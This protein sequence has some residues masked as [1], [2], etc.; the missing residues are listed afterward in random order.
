M[1]I[2]KDK[3]MVHIGNGHAPEHA[4]LWGEKNNLVLAGDQIISSISPNL[5]VY[6]TEPDAD[7]VG[8]WI[9]SCERFLLFA[10]SQQL[11][12]SGHKLPFTGLSARLNQLVRNHRSCLDRLLSFLS[13]PR[14]ACDC[15]EP[16]FKKK[17]GK[18]E[19]LLALAESVAHLNHLQKLGAVVRDVDCQGVYR[20]TRAEN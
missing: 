7:P 11:V 2:G 5:G 6:A 1:E 14:S 13:V 12:L 4:T 15:F 9:E 16:L 8:E 17:I 18:E 19:Y 3:W 10:K 20:Y